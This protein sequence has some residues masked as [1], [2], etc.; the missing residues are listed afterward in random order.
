VLHHERAK[1]NAISQKRRKIFVGG[2]SKHV[3]ENDLEIFFQNFGQVDKTII[4]REHYTNVSRGCGF[5]IFKNQIDANNVLKFK[6]KFILKGKEFG[7]KPCL[8]KEEIKKMN[9]VN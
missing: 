5:V 3:T 9:G 4:T 7:V 1:E 8:L 2:L 6:G